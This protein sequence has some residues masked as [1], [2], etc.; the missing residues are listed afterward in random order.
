MQIKMNSIPR[1]TLQEFADQHGLVMEIYERDTKEFPLLLRYYAR[2][3]NCE[4]SDGIVLISA[5]GNGKTPDDAME[6]YTKQISG[7]K[8]IVST[9]ET[10]VVIHAPSLK[11]VHCSNY[12]S[13]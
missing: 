6:D 11:F 5:F 10:R 2:F 4:I 9:N 13:V 7:K 12:E 3:E 8:L 1:T